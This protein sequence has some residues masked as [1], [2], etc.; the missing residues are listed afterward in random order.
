MS[1]FL[2]LLLV[3]APDFSKAC[4]AKQ[5]LQRWRETLDSQCIAFP[6]SS[7]AKVRLSSYFTA[8]LGETFHL[9]PHVEQALQATP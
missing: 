6:I 7:L 1:N 4:I 9:P 5:L 3:Q 8:G 2:I